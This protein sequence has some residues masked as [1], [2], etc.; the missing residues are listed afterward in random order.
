MLDAFFIGAAEV[1]YDRYL[2]LC[3]V[4]LSLHM[5]AFLNRAQHDGMLL[6]SVV[7]GE[8]YDARDLL[9][10]ARRQMTRERFEELKERLYGNDR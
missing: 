6:A 10:P 3:P 2:Y 7:G 4:E 8:P 9:R 5:R 1:P